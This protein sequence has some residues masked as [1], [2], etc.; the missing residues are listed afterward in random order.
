[1]KS[2]KNILVTAELVFVGLC[3]S[4]QSIT[5]VE[6][7]VLGNNVK[8]FY[9]VH[10]LRFNQTMTISVYVSQNKGVTYQGP[11]QEV[12]GHV[13]ENIFNG[14]HYIIW[15]PMKELQ[16]DKAYAIFDV[17]GV[18]V[19][20]K[21]ERSFFASYCGNLTAPFGLRTGVLGGT[22]FYVMGQMN[23][24]PFLSG[25]YNYEDGTITDYNRFAWYE[26]T[27][28]HKVSA[29][30]FCAG[31]T[32]Q[33]AKN[34]FLYGGAGYSKYEVLYEI[35]EYSYNGDEF[36]GKNYGRDTKTSKRGV[37]FEAGL[38]LRFRN[39]IIAGGTSV[40]SYNLPDW[41][42]GIGYNF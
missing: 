10:G 17:R 28:N 3:L 18:V 22:G 6:P 20:N 13:G 40:I 2:L 41:Q 14:E 8:I 19:T 27:S 42:V 34:M 25:S 24:Q 36:L 7:H 4:A 1:M 32:Y 29:Y 12:S 39:F 21:I 37:A 23:A 30:L 15:E 38:V 26:F 11:L 9:D 5:Q 33:V 31:I 16:L 35:N